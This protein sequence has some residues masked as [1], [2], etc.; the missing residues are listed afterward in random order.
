VSKPTIR[1]YQLLSEKYAKREQQRAVSSIAA[2][3][4]SVALGLWSLKRLR[5]E[6][7]TEET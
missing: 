3:V 2:G 6:R 7:N 1:E 5:D 4:V